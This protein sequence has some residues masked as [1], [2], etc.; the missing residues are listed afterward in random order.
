MNYPTEEQAHRLLKEYSI[1]EE[2]INHSIE[3]CGNSVI[4]G[5]QIA[6]AGDQ[7]DL[8][9]LKVG[10]LLHDIGRWKYCRERGYSPDQDFHEYET[11]SLLRELGFV[12]FGN[13]LQRHSLGGLTPEETVALG[14]PEAIDLMPNTL[15]VKIIC[16]ADKIRPKEGIVSLSDKIKD[17][18]E[19][20]RLH[21]R[22]FNKLPGLL[23]K[24]IG[25]VTTIWQELESLG[26]KSLP[27]DPKG[28]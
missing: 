10:G 17:Y 3:V 16:I 20:Q 7:V 26:M 24:T 12:D 9:L 27:I 14:F 2:I 8:G 21:Q 1:P 5:T 6:K 15:D 18:H 13:M 23:G 11:G 4:I 22:Y 25:R 19:N 28:Y